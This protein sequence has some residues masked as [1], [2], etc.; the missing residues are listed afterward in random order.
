MEE[1]LRAIKEFP[2]PPSIKLL[3][4]FLGLANQ[5]FHFIPDGAQ[6]SEPLRLLVKLETAF[7]W[8]PEQ[9][10]AFQAYKNALNHLLILYHFN[11]KLKTILITDA[12]RVGLGYLLYQESLGNDPPKKRII[13]CGSMSVSGAESRYVSWRN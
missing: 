3:R 5:L 2:A 10:M 8:G 13:Q 11:P 9:E 6:M 12:S 1:R 7:I 4:G